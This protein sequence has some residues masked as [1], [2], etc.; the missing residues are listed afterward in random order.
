MNRSQIR[1]V[2]RS[3][4]SVAM[5]ALV[6]LGAIAS[7]A[8]QAGASPLQGASKGPTALPNGPLPA[9]NDGPDGVSIGAEELAPAARPEPRRPCS[10]TTAGW[11]YRPIKRVYQFKEV[12]DRAV[13]NN[14]G[15]SQSVTKKITTTVS[16]TKSVKLSASFSYGTSGG[17]DL[18]AVRLGVETTWDLSASGTY[19]LTKSTKESTSFKVG[20]NKR[21]YYVHGFE[22]FKI[23]GK[24][25][26]LDGCGRVV[27]TKPDV[28][29]WVPFG[30]GTK[31]ANY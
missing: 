16:T 19:T 7:P 4:T 8:G 9:P 26:R 2:R 13:I 6:A 21:L 30:K 31:F 11:R 14:A 23:V 24:Y 5:V 17:I 22:Q 25:Y 28:T 29:A 27:E 15:N 1:P 20:A 10:A 12:P 18:K 3:V